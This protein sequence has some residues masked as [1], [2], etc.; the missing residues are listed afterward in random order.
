[1]LALGCARAAPEPSVEPLASACDAPSIDTWSWRRVDRGDFT[2]RV[3]PNF[4]ALDRGVDPWRVVFMNGRHLIEL[5]SLQE[6]TAWHRRLIAIGLFASCTNEVGSRFA[7][8]ISFRGNIGE[9]AIAAR[10]AAAD[11]G[12]DLVIT[13]SSPDKTQLERLRE[14]LWT[15]HFERDP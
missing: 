14:V 10:W 8:V 15:V 12:R 1:M 5:E 2:L 13:I 3:P 6:A 9:H 7:D 11:A 4:A